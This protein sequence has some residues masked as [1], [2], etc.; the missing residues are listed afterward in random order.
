[1]PGA[2]CGCRAAVHPERRR[3]PAL[4]SRGNRSPM[5]G[6]TRCYFRPERHRRTPGKMNGRRSPHGRTWLTSH[7]HHLPPR[8]RVSR[9][10][11]AVAR[12]AHARAHGDALARRASAPHRD[13]TGPPRAP[14]VLE[15]SK[16]SKP[17]AAGGG[18]R[19]RADRACRRAIASP[20]SHR[21]H[22]MSRAPGPRRPERGI[23]TRPGSEPRPGQTRSDPVSPDPVSTDE[24][25][26]PHVRIVIPSRAE[27]PR[28]FP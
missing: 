20:P 1:L 5:P 6:R 22:R 16:P 27:V 7:R 3:V 25:G 21:Q 4:R 15:A 14:E 17:P 26:P 2:S 23:R 11:H 10:R 8:L 19:R 12:H 28:V 13:S 9:G 24:E 18:R